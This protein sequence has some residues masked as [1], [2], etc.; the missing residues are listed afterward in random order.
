MGVPINGN[1]AFGLQRVSTTAAAAL[2]TAE[3]VGNWNASDKE[4]EEDTWEYLLMWDDN[5]LESLWASLQDIKDPGVTD[6]VDRFRAINKNTSNAMSFLLSLLL[7]V[8]CSAAFVSV[9]NVRSTV[10]FKVS[11]G[12]G[13]APIADS[14]ALVINSALPP[15]YNLDNSLVPPTN[16]DTYRS[17]AL[18]GNSEQ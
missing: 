17:A 18:D 4:W 2:C 1:P 3:P 11:V 14:Y 13:Y 15:I 7:L 12:I 8:P 9:P 10:I 16:L 6:E 5:L